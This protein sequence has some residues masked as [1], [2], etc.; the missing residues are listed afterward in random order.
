MG[1]YKR[2]IFTRLA[3]MFLVLLATLLITILLVGSNMD[4][5]LKQGVAIQVRAEIAENPAVT[6]SFESVQELEQYIQEQINQKTTGVG[7]RRAV[8]LAS[9]SRISNVQG[10]DTRFR[11]C[12]ISDK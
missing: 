1:G 6:K 11:T 4:I 2:F 3:T 9:K 8:V 5:I 10:P 12:N 7:T